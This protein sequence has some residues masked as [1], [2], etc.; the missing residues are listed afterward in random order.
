M[1]KMYEVTI[2]DT[3]NCA[4]NEIYDATTIIALFLILAK[5]IDNRDDQYGIKKIIIE[6]LK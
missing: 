3:N 1:K 2:I 5:E 6:E 4:T